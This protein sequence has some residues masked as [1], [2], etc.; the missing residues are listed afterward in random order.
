[1]WRVQAI[2]VHMQ[3]MEADVTFLEEVTYSVH[4]ML[5]RAQKWEGVGNKGGRTKEK[6]DGGRERGGG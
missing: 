4:I 5:D 2:L 1:M 6:N 3:K